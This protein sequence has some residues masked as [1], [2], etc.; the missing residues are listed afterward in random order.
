M[1]TFTV[2]G[3]SHWQ[4]FRIFLLEGLILLIIG[5]ILGMPIAFYL[6][7]L[8]FMSFDTELFRFPVMIYFDRLYESAIIM[9]VF[10]AISYAVVLRFIYKTVWQELLNVRE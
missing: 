7:K 1:A 4:I 3:L 5:I 10:F 9:L 8:F 2:L 6:S